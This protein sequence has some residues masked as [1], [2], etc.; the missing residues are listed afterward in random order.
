MIGAFIFQKIKQNSIIQ[1]L[2]ISI[3]AGLI[4]TLI[5]TMLGSLFGNPL[6]CARDI[7]IQMGIIRA[8]EPTPTPT[9]EPTPYVEPT[10]IQRTSE[11]FNYTID[12]PSNFTYEGAAEQDSEDDF[13]LTSPDKRT[14]IVFIA[15]AADELPEIFTIED[16]R[17]AYSGTILY[18]DDRIENDGWYVISAKTPDGFFRYRK[19]IYTDG[20]ARMYTFSFPTDQEDIYLKEFD[21]VSRIEKSFTKLHHD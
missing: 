11:Q 16:F 9:P 17:N 5:T 8:P 1:S 21:Y 19:C 14:N 20:V 15:R 10:F 13:N 2:L 6:E 18:E 4:V 12:V 3:A 7:G